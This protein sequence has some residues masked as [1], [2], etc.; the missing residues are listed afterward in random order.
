M[1]TERASAR[2]PA[3]TRFAALVVESIVETP[4]TRTL[5]LDVGV[6]VTYRAGQYVS[7]D[8]H[9]FPALRSIT[10]YLE[11]AKGRAEAPR[12]YS[13]CS[14]PSEPYVAITVKEEVYDGV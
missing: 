1:A 2:V 7:I 8:P 10:A 14:E 3:M 5:V 6:P 4:D 12:A 9:Q 13:M 11:H